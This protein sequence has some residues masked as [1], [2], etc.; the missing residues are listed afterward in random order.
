[1]SYEDRIADGTKAVTWALAGGSTGNLKPTPKQLVYCAFNSTNVPALR[2]ALREV[3]TDDSEEVR[4]QA[5]EVLAAWDNM[6]ME[7]QK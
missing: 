1:M 4:K 6:E 7:A 3:L 5:A 2:E